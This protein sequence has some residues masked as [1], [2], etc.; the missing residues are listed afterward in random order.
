VKPL[1]ILLLEDDPLDAELTLDK[2]GGS[3]LEFEA[4]RA[5]V[6]EEFVALLQ[7]QRFDLILSDYLLPSFDGMAALELAHQL[8]PDVPFIF[9][10]GVI[11]EEKAIET[12]K[13]GATDYVLKHRLERLVPSVQRALRENGERLQRRKAETALRLLAEAS[14]VLSSSLDYN[15]TL[16][17][18]SRLAIPFFADLCFVDVIEKD[19]VRRVAAEHVDPQMQTLADEL[20]NYAPQPGSTHAA[21]LTGV[22][23]DGVPR[24]VE[25]ISPELLEASTLP[26]RHL[27]LHRLLGSESGMIVPMASHGKILGAMTFVRT[28]KSP[29]YTA[30]DL[31][32][33]EDLAHRAA[34]AIDN[35]RLY[36]EAQ[37]ANRAKDEFLA[38]ISHELRT[39]LMAI[40]GWSSMLRTE[41]L[42]EETTQRALETI[43]RNAQVQSNLI[44][45]I[46][47]VSRIMSGKLEIEHLPVDL[48][49]I[50]RSALEVVYPSAQDKNIQLEFSARATISP[51]ENGVLGD[52]Q[53]LQQIVWNLLSNAVKF[54]PSGGHVRVELTQD[55]K[56]AIILVHDDGQG[57]SAEFLP[58]VFERFRQADGTSTR[59]HGG[60]GL[61]LSIVRQLTQLH[62]GSVEAFSD[63]DGTGATFV[64]RLP[65]QS[66]R[67]CEDSVSSSD[68]PLSSAVDSAQPPP[69]LDG[70][71]ILLVED[72]ADARDV[73]SIALQRWGAQ[74]RSC[75]CAEDGLREWKTQ[76]P[77]LI[78]SDVGM[79]GMN[80]HQ[81]LQR[82][83]EIETE[84]GIVDGFRTP[85]IAL[86]AFATSG[87]SE[88]A[89]DAGFQLHL[90]KPVEPG[91]LVRAA[92]EVAKSHKSHQ[93]S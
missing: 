59:R 9:V 46:L 16:K 31:V 71:R 86:T 10:S 80:G 21:M 90:A 82:I 48:H 23:R 29:R 55:E 34:L 61:G 24:L 30:S 25:H 81:F 72:E 62:G 27:E 93:P 58:L 66:A 57:I 87:D 43:E 77:D 68:Y 54:T 51:D 5:R 6:R 73:V 65:L 2:L 18:I 37:D 50:I 53:R 74:V 38:T 52:A 88:K 40:L 41:K 56:D 12:L 22:M 60:L 13:M 91:K 14:N 20:K 42:D 15:I 39:P 7:N 49:E 36:R 78:I 35:A 63:G 1:A 33:A 84:S 76:R 83:R 45:D 85:A 44:C 47:D 28:A 17:N 89:L 32:L 3:E 8:Q 26:G 67:N 75:E 70:V 11:G 79:P 64:V 4:S 69:L 19:C 92:A